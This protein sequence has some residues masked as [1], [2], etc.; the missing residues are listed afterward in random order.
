MKEYYLRACRE[1]EEQGIPV[2]WMWTC[3]PTEVVRGM[4]LN[5]FMLEYHTG[6]LSGR[7]GAHRYFEAAEE[8]GYPR[9]SCSFQKAY[10]GRSLIGEQPSIVPPDVLVASTSCDSS[11]RG[12]LLLADHYRVP[13]YLLDLPW[14]GQASEGPGLPES[15]VAY[16]TAQLEELVSLLARVTGHPL[17]SERLTETYRR[18]NRLYQLWEEIV[19]L[20]GSIPCPVGI[21]DSVAAGGVLMQFAG[22][23]EGLDFVER[24]REEVRERV[25][26]NQGVL[27]EER[28]RL[29]WLGPIVNYDLGLF[30]Y[31]EELGAV[32][33]QWELECSYTG[34]YGGLLDPANPLESMA[35]KMVSNLYNGALENRMEAI[36][37]LAGRLKVDGLVLFNTWPCK[38]LAGS[39]RAIKERVAQELGLPLLFLEAD[40]VDSRSYAPETLRQQIED[41]VE[42]LS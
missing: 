16:L 13:Y 15:P 11:P 8:G 19:D 33:L 14:N 9:D 25:V 35:R 34:S 3:T 7:E 36:R 23:Q 6:F 4:G 37:R 27:E 42:M 28:C 29:L 32:V 41:F 40:S 5:P 22:T 39:Q 21:A 24:M 31:F 30:H 10:L 38:R 2:A 1:K 26:Q 17:D 12:L 18:A 20:K